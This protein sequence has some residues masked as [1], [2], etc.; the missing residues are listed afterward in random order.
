MKKI[1]DK[2]IELWWVFPIVSIFCCIVATLETIFKFGDIIFAIAFI[3]SMLCIPIQVVIF[4]IT[5]LRKK[6]KTAI[7]VFIG[8]FIN[9]VCFCAWLFFT[10]IMSLFSPENDPFGKEHPIP[11]DLEC[12]IPLANELIDF[13]KYE[14]SYEEATIDTLNSDTWLQIWTEVKAE[15][16]NTTSIIR[17]LPTAPY[18]YAATK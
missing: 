1:I 12:N 17:S 15:Y 9:A 16:M 6:W 7:G 3:L 8:G 18:I 13:E 14:Y 11:I 4:I 10:L 5:L 2:L